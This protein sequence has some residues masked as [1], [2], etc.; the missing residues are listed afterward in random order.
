MTVTVKGQITIPQALRER[1]GLQPGT[2]VE[3]V[4]GEDALQVKP[5]KRSRRA[6]T[7]F[8]AWLVKAAGSATTKLTTDQIMATTRGED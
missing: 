6:A 5:R 7:A 8:D 2:E 1:F 4:A 3:F